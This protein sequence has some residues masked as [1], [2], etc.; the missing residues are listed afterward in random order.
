MSSSP[1]FPPPEPP[2]FNA[3]WLLIAAICFGWVF[4]V[5]TK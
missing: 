2:A 4:L 1:K 3:G 5:L